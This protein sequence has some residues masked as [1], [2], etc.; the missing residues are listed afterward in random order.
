VVHDKATYVSGAT[1]GFAE[2]AGPSTGYEATAFHEKLRRR[3]DYSLGCFVLR[4]TL[5]VV[6]PF[7]TLKF[8]LMCWA[9]SRRETGYELLGYI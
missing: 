1:L 3:L 5:P 2:G 6:G 4:R 8:F 9:D 7:T